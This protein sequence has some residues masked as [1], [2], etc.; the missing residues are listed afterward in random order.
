MLAKLIGLNPLKKTSKKNSVGISKKVEAFSAEYYKDE[1]ESD[2][3]YVIHDAYW[4]ENVL[5]DAQEVHK[6]SDDETEPEEKKDPPKVMNKNRDQYGKEK[7]EETHSQLVLSILKDWAMNTS[8][9]VFK[10]SSSC[11][12]II[13]LNILLINDT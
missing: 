6:M 11:K 3:R 7:K 10:L 13:T 9:Y 8:S 1:K 12:E 5:N 4:T 2:H